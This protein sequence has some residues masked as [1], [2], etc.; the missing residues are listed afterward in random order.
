MTAG[1]PNLGRC[2]D[3]PFGPATGTSNMSTTKAELGKAVTAAGAGR[4]GG[5]PSFG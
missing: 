3:E 5:S 1:I 4:V 2:G